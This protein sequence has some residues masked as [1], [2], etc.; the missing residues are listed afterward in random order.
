MT[1]DELQCDTH[2]RASPGVS[3]RQRV[4]AI[5]PDFCG[6]P[7]HLH[8]LDVICHNPQEEKRQRAHRQQIVRELEAALASLKHIR[9]ESHSKR[10]CQLRASRRYGRSLRLTKGGLRRIDVAKQRAA[11]QLEGKCVGHSNDESLTPTDVAL[12]YKQRQRVEEAWRSL[13]S[14]LRVRPVYHWAVHRI[15]AHVAVSGLAL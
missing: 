12:G 7:Q 6:F 9:G 15:Q 5:L 2:S 4:H 14:G 3:G 8:A 10:V 11:A 13:K 1:D